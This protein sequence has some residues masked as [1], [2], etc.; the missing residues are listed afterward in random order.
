MIHPEFEARITWQIWQAA[1][2]RIDLPRFR[3][4]FTGGFAMAEVEDL[5]LADSFTPPA[6][7]MTLGAIDLDPLA[8][9]HGDQTTVI[10]ISIVWPPPLRA[11]D[12]RDGLR[13][14]LLDD[15]RATLLLDYGQLRTP[16]GELLT[17]G[18][19]RFQRL[20]PVEAIPRVKPQYLL[21]RLRV[22]Y[23]SHVLSDL[24]FEG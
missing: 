13:P 18:L 4:Y 24:N 3:E 6:L 23:R 9:Q 12:V 8:S 7:G 22:A 21:D 1:F 2:A 20:P 5:F 19:T 11:R 15:L 17:E 16:E 10:E 14:R